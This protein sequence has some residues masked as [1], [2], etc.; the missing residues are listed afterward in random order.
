MIVLLKLLLAHFIGD[1][2]LQPKSWVAKKEREK[3]KSPQLYFH[4][5][6]HGVLAMLLLWDFRYWSLALVLTVVHWLID[7]LKLY[8]QG[9]NNRPQ[10]F[11]ADQFMHIASV[12]ALWFVWVKPDVANVPAWFSTPDFWVY[13]TAMVFITVV[14]AISI[15]VVMT[16]WT[17]ELKDGE[18]NSLTQAGRYIGILERLFVFVFVVAGYWGAIGFLLAAKSIF[19]FG[20]LRRAKDRKLTEYILIGTLL[21][22]GIAMAAGLGVLGLTGGGLYIQ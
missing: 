8:G 9:K 20:D 17:S 5:L 22:F 10:W 4:V 12:V 7:V 16:N 18:T 15:Q 3:A 11:L 6:I 13:V 14:A 2:V 1:F 19:R 21:S